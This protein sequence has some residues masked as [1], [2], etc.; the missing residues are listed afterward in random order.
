MIQELLME[1]WGPK[2]RQGT[3]QFQSNTGLVADGYVGYQLF[4][5]I[6]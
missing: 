1:M 4:H 3:R 2:N 5:Q 6:K